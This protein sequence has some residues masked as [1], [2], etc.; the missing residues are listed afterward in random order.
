M[1]KIRPLRSDLKK[2]LQKR[3]LQKKFEKQME[4]MKRNVHHPSLHTEV[5]E[6]RKFRIFS[7]RVDK[8]YRAIYIYHNGEIEIIDINPHYR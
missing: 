1:P 7:F 2:Y 4:Y 8:K 5:L 6:P 3:H